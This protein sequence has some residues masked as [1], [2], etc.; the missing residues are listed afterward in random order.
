MSE[1]T[2]AEIYAKMLG[3]QNPICKSEI[4]ADFGYQDRKILPNP[5]KIHILNVH[6]EWL[7]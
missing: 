3:I 2:H 1:F 5:L 4:L 6:N 7:E